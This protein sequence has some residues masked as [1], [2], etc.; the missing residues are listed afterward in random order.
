MKKKVKLA[1]LP[2]S[3]RTSKLDPASIARIHTTTKAGKNK[4]MKARTGA[5]TKAKICIIT[6][7]GKN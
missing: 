6:K 2:I 7:T 5:A 1:Q 4:P 3:T